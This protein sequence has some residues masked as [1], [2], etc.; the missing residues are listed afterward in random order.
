MKKKNE[1]TINA[2][3]HLRNIVLSKS[4]RRH[5]RQRTLSKRSGHSLTLTP[6]LANTS[7]RSHSEGS[8]QT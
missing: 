1:E 7:A 3:I 2:F 6:S 8:M 5:F 4:L